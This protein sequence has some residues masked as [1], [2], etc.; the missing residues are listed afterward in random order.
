M[1]DDRSFPEDENL[2]EW[3]RG[4]IHPEPEEPAQEQPPAPGAP[5]PPEEAEAPAP[6]WGAEVD[7]PPTGELPWLE[8]LEQPPAASAASLDDLSEDLPWLKRLS[9]QPEEPGAPQDEEPPAG[10][11]PSIT[12]RDAPLADWFAQA[13]PP[14]AAPLPGDAQPPQE[15]GDEAPPP[16]EAI[17]AWLAAQEPPQEEE[18]APG[19]ET[20]GVP[21][22]LAGEFPTGTGEAGEAAPEPEAVPAWLAGAEDLAAEFEEFEQSEEQEEAPAGEDIPAWLAG[23]EDFAATFEEPEE[24]VEEGE[25]VPAGAA[26]DWLIRETDELPPPESFDEGGL[27]YEEWEQLQAEAGREPDETEQLAAEVPDWFEEIAGA[28]PEEEAAPSPAEAPPPAQTG[29]EFVPEWYLGLEERDASEAPD[30]FSDLDFSPQALTTEPVLPE[31]PPPA[32]EA[33]PPQQEPTPPAWVAELEETGTGPLFPEEPPTTGEVPDWFA[34]AAG[35]TPPT[36]A[37]VPDWFAEIEQAET[38]PE[39]AAEEPTDW[40]A[41]FEAQPP[42]PAPADALAPGEVPDWLAEVAPED[43]TRPPQEEEERPLSAEELVAQGRALDVMGLI[44]EETG[45]KPLEALGITPEVAPDAALVGEQWASFDLDDLLSEQE[46]ALQEA[47]GEPGGPAPTPQDA[48]GLPEWLLEARPTHYGRGPS[49]VDI[50]LRTPET[51]LEELSD[52]LKALRRQ[53][54]QAAAAEAAAA[55][56]AAAP[57]ASQVLA[58]VTDGLVP[59]RAFEEPTG[60][61]VATA[62]SLDKAQRARVAALESLLGLG[63]PA[64]QYD[65]AGAPIPLDEAVEAVRIREAA[66]RARARSRRKPDRLLLSL[67]LLVALVLPFFLDVSAWVRLPQASLNEEPFA[68]LEAA[69]RRLR[70]RDLVLVGFEYGPTAAGELDALA[71]TL[72]TRVL[73]ERARPVVISTNPAG[74]LHARDL[75]ATLAQDPLLLARLGRPPDRPLTMPADYVILSYL[76]GGVVGLRALTATSTEVNALDRGIFAVDLQGNPTGL[77]VRF[78]QVSFDLVLTL[79]ERAE[80]VRLWVEQVGTVVDLPLA[81]GV[82]LAAEPVARQYVDSGQLIGLLAGY[83]DAYSYDRALQEALPPVTPLPPGSGVEG[84]SDSGGELALLPTPTA[85][86]LLP[87][88]TPLPEGLTTRVPSPTPTAT[89]TPTGTPTPTPTATLRPAEATGTARALD[90]GTPTRTPLPTQRA[91]VTATPL[92]PGRQADQTATAQAEAQEQAAPPPGQSYADRRWYSM[93]V[94]AV[95]ATLLIG[96]GALVNIV[97][98]IR[99]RGEP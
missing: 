67:L 99:R 13:P 34:E 54:E 48:E 71:E 38:P 84:P 18:A 68:A 88:N 8:D 56:A 10:A 36:E 60:P 12:D 41:A 3:L 33:P 9:P 93:G 95:M 83:R 65:G 58:G 49:A 5:P 14:P 1:T 24:P 98:A 37:E 77:N 96:L 86:S 31:E 85:E 75:L 73:L 91:F 90:S 78:L 79:A 80:D 32:G 66:R 50:A 28:E 20:G 42:A 87:T 43:M 81:A 82:S 25:G 15:A 89:L 52:R 6:P 70:P 94:G 57:A 7:L 69:M 55:E 30:W 16:E 59:A 22:W 4:H 40:I 64:V 72:L 44:E 35:P 92:P 27:T 61:E 63:A 97:R 39:P 17:P 19:P 45:A 23:V 11:G 2:P 62:I 26:P 29:P 46:K 51:P 74:I 76:P 21:D 47:A 53:A